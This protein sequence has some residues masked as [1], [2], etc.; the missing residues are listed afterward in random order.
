MSCGTIGTFCKTKFSVYWPY[1]LAI[2]AFLK[3]FVEDWTCWCVMI[4]STLKISVVL[5]PEVVSVGCFS[6]AFSIK[7]IL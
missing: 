6:S 4:V 1:F 5:L 3:L 2:F 7:P